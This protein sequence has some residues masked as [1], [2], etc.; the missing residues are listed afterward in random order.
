VEQSPAT[1]VITDLDANIQYVNP[2]FTQVTGYSATEAI[3]QNPR[4]LR[5]KLTPSSTYVALWEKLTHGLPWQGELI[6]QRKNGEQFWEEAHIAPIKDAQGGT[7]H[8]VAVKVDIT[9]RIRSAQ[10]LA[11]LVHEQQ[12]I[13]NNELIGIAT[14]RD[15]RFLWANPAYAH[16]L[17]HEPEELTGMAT[18]QLYGSEADYQTETAA[19][20]TVLAAGQKYRSRI[21]QVR[22]DGRLIW[23]DASGATLDPVTGET[24]WGFI[25][26]TQHVQMEEQVRQLAFYDSLTGLAN[27]RL[28]DDRLKQCIHWCKRSGC[29]A[30]L[31]FLDLDNFKPLNDAHGHK[32]GDLLLMEV[33][34]RI[35]ACV[36]E[37]DTV[38]RF[39]GD[40]FVVLLGELTGESATSVT[41]AGMVAEKIRTAIGRGFLLSI[42]D[43]SE[44]KPRTAEHHCSASIG[45]AMIGPDEAAA[46]DVLL[47]ADKAMYEAKEHGRNQVW[48]SKA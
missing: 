40:E 20:N 34:T 1:V 45:V 5:S 23:L 25:D 39:G 16:M 3:G 4:I 8:Y 28:F 2:R 13:L 24:L 22:K 12:A 9:E 38:A 19:A 33:A 26:I 7:T 11:S 37:T 27:R 18:R 48:F 31:L 29:Y 17:G 21:E 36:R 32:A 41:E 44:H 30:A 6:N 15:N 10:K 47:R 35:K 43:E 46:E 14:V 42:P